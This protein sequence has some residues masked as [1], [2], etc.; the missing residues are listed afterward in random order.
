ME[1]AVS[2]AKGKLRSMSQL[3]KDLCVLTLSQSG[4][5]TPCENVKE[6]YLFI[7][8]TDRIQPS[9]TSGWL[10]AA[11][12]RGGSPA[13]EADI[14]VSAV[15]E[16][17]PTSALFPWLSVNLRGVSCGFPWR[18]S[19]DRSQRFAGADNNVWK[20]RHYLACR[21]EA[22]APFLS[23]LGTALGTVCSQPWPPL[24]GRELI[25]CLASPSLKTTVMFAFFTFFSSFKK[26]SDIN[27]LS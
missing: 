17:R 9:Q 2:G 19:V 27:S 16:P 24:A 14:P 6:W 5:T 20:D 13:E 22:R 10:Q 26:Q 8:H 3:Q 18:R 4:L 21:L 1:L 15:S 25:S 7:Y 23:G 11:G 12:Q